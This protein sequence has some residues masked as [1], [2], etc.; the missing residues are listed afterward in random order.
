[1]RGRGRVRANVG[2]KSRATVGSGYLR[3]VELRKVAARHVGLEKVAEGRRERDLVVVVTAVVRH[4]CCCCCCCYL[5]RNYY[6]TDESATSGVERHSCRYRSRA[7]RRS[8]T[9]CDCRLPNARLGGSACE[10]WWEVVGGG[11][12]DE[13][14]WGW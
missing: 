12:G 1:M 14:W 3:V 4:C 5:F 6:Y 8:S 10:G 13:G 7:M 2:V 11:G 9:N